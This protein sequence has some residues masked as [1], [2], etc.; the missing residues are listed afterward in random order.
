MKSVTESQL[1]V[2]FTLKGK[3]LGYDEVPTQ[4]VNDPGHCL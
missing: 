1:G 2:Y 4:V 3:K